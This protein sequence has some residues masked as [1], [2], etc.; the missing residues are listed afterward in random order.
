MVCSAFFA[1]DMQNYSKSVSSKSSMDN[2]GLLQDVYNRAVK[3]NARDRFTL[4][5]ELGHFYCILLRGSTLHEAKCQCIW[6]LNGKL[7]FSLGN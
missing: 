3:G 4:C 7:M 1:L 5:H 2:Q 6:I